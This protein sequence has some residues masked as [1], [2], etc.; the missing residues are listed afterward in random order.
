MQQKLEVE[1]VQLCAGVQSFW[2][3]HRNCVACMLKL[4]FQNTETVKHQLENLSGYRMPWGLRPHISH[5]TVSCTE[6]IPP[7]LGM[8]AS[9]MLR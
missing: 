1:R 8:A 6:V 2:T 7:V 4:F 5:S 9:W 3:S